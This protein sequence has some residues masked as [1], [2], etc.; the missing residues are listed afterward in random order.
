M[1][2]CIRAPN[3]KLKISRKGIIVQSSAENSAILSDEKKKEKK[4]RKK[5]R[6]GMIGKKRDSANVLWRTSTTFPTYSDDYARKK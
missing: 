5:M 3:A 6:A 2:C 1:L 4:R